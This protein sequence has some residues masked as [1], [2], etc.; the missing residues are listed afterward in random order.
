MKKLY[1]I[2]SLFLFTMVGIA[3][4]STSPNPVVA[5]DGSP[6]FSHATHKELAECATC[7]EGA[8]QSMSAEEILRPKPEVCTSCHEE[9]DVRTFW[10]LS[11]GDAL[12]AQYLHVKN[13]NLIFAHKPHIE[14]GNMQCADC[15]ASTMEGGDP[16]IP[17][18]QMCYQ[19]HN[20]AEKVAPIIQ[21]TSNEGKYLATSR[22]CEMCH[23]TLAGMIPE[24]HRVADF[25]RF[26][27]LYAQN[28][29]ADRDCAVCHSQSFCQECHAPTNDVSL[30]TTKDKF[31]NDMW[32]R[33]EKMDDGNLFSIQKVHVLTYRY[34]H[35][36][37]A[38]AK[39]SRCETC[40]EPEGFCTPCHEN[41][42]DATGTRI[43]PQSH[44]LAGFV[45]LGGNRALNRHA[46][47]ASMD[48]ESCATCHNVD[49]ADPVCAMCHST[50]IVKGD[51]K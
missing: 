41:G 7:H 47:L 49:G 21:H 19:C 24:N 6:T 3:L 13:R 39:S 36:F 32:P 28:G 8:V 45:T 43:V 31:Y 2:L 1:F 4:V 34:T 18:M 51:S 27:G 12:D 23:T 25:S 35:G 9:A 33:G 37:D 44:Q 29:E 11:E 16:I 50:G 30:G 26:H 40:H 10:S 38:R 48:M 20:N 15:H 14:K 46:K 42:F 5:E 22:Q 17:S